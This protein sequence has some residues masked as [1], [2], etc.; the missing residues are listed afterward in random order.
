MSVVKK[1]RIES[2]VMRSNSISPKYSENLARV[3]PYTFAV[4]FPRVHLVI[5]PVIADG[6]KQF[7]GTPP[8]V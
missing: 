4:F 8:L 1:E 2:G 3:F 5:I 7:H 6:V